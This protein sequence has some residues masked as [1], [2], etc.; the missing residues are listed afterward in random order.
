MDAC[1]TPRPPRSA[2]PRS[3]MD[4]RPAG[5]M[6]RSSVPSRY[7]DGMD[8]QLRRARHQ[9]AGEGLGLKE[10][11]GSVSGSSQRLGRT[12]QVL[13]CILLGLIEI[14]EQ[15]PAGDALIGGRVGVR[16]SPRLRTR[17]SPLA[18]SC[19]AASNATTWSK[20]AGEETSAH[21]ALRP[22]H[23]RV[24][25]HQTR[26]RNWR[27]PLGRRRSGQRVELAESA[28]GGSSTTQNTSTIARR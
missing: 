10:L 3:A 11:S 12:A 28:R 23:P 5:G 25:C 19:C 14:R 24:P 8:R 4:R 7:L 15:L 21:P 26:A 18:R 6:A 20:R 22:T 13:V 2:F 27:I 17:R 1:V 9:T 16:P